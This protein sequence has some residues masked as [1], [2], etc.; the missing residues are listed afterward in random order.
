MTSAS[1]SISD[2]LQ[3][4][5]RL[6]VD[7]PQNVNIINISTT[8]SGLCWIG[9]SQPALILADKDGKVTA[10]SKLRNI[11][12][13][14][15]SLHNSDAVYSSGSSGG[16]VIHRVDTKGAVTEF[17]NLW[18]LLQNNGS[19]YA[20]C[21]DA[22]NNVLAYI[23]GGHI[24][25]LSENG[26]LLEK[27][28]IFEGSMARTVVTELLITPDG[29]RLLRAGHDLLTFDQMWK[30]CFSKTLSF[31]DDWEFIVCDSHQ[32]ML[33]YNR[34]DDIIH[35][36]DKHNVVLRTFKLQDTFPGLDLRCMTVNNKN[37]LWLA[38]KDGEI[39]LTKYL[40]SDSDL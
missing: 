16:P 39:L 7:L 36:M 14:L 28:K 30:R 17:A 25:K 8:Q 9:T 10:Q 33:I 18:K 5:G 21:V 34:E 19:V 27:V 37:V 23:A 32:N 31:G 13:Y 1:G 26:D 12:S 29:E 15:A 6:Q 22:G 38:A 24:V 3:L 35:V 4:C 40:P 11:P 20:M 2:C